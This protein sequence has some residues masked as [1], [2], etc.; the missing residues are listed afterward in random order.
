MKIDFLLSFFHSFS[1]FCTD[2]KRC[3]FL[4]LFFLDS[5]VCVCA[6]HVDGNRVE[7]IHLSSSFFFLPLDEERKNKK[8]LREEKT[9]ESRKHSL[10]STSIC[11][12]IVVDSVVV[13]IGACMN[14]YGSYSHQQTFCSLAFIHPFFSFFLLCFLFTSSTRYWVSANDRSSPPPP[15]HQQYLDINGKKRK[16][17]N[18]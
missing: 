16:K 14:V 7:E 8:D 12:C 3:S 17:H 15:T 9:K 18:K 2:A 5:M 1:F 13:V 10:S 6:Q 4:F 11:F